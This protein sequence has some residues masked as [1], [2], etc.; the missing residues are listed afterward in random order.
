M[1]F[2]KVLCRCGNTVLRYM[3]YIP[4]VD[5]SHNAN[6]ICF[7]PQFTLIIA[8]ITVQIIHKGTI[9]Q[10]DIKILHVDNSALR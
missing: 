6:I 1:P 4:R 10:R 7:Q 2:I 8:N 3:Q 5:F 9:K